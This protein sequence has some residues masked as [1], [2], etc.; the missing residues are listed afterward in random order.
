MLLQGVYQ[1]MLPLIMRFQHW[2]S[3]HI[4]NSWPQL[5]PHCP[6]VVL[7]ALAFSLLMLLDNLGEFPTGRAGLWGIA[8]A[9]ETPAPSLFGWHEGPVQ[10]GSLKGCCTMV[11]T[12]K[13]QLVSL[14][15]TEGWCSGDG[16]EDQSFWCL[17]AL[18][19]H[20]WQPGHLATGRPRSAASQLA[21]QKASRMHKGHSPSSACL[22]LY[23]V[24]WLWWW[25][26][27]FSL[28]LQ[29]ITNPAPQT[30]PCCC[31]NGQAQGPAFVLGSPFQPHWG[32]QEGLAVVPS[33]PSPPWKSWG[34]PGNQRRCAG[35]RFGHKSY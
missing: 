24:T 26:H 17:Q 5:C 6:V 13:V 33:A 32:A 25:F 1:L 30:L 29:R 15:N 19:L 14:W 35:G 4:S 2:P 31:R 11:I 12:G 34:Y 18:H 10:S 27:S 8:E 3:S 23:V 22:K 7:L 16:C 28:Y 20:M 21:L 9:N